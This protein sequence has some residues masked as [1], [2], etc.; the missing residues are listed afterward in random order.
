MDAGETDTPENAAARKWRNRKDRVPSEPL[1]LA[2]LDP[3]SRRRALLRCAVT[4][5]LCWVIL[6]GAF[7]VVPIGDKSSLRA[8]VRLGADIALIGAVFAWQIRRISTAELP[9]LRAIEALG[10]VVVLFLVAF[11]GLYLG[12]SHQSPLSF[13]QRLDQTRALY[14]TITIFST[15]GF[16][17]ITPRTDPARLVVS[18]QMLLDLAIIGA[19]VRLIFNA[20]KNRVAPATPSVS[21][22]EP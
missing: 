3:A 7:Y 9:E 11:A 6:L 8:F 12:M 18:A 4:I 10:I 22:S 15:V 5:L 20:A 14:F 13:T 2:D 17:D 21:T 16:G 1:R 19:A